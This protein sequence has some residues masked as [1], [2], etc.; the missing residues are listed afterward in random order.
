VGKEASG[1][2]LLIPPHIAF[3]NAVII[4]TIAKK[5]L[6]K[7]PFDKKELYNTK[8]PTSTLISA[9]SFNDI[10]T[11]K[12][13][14]QNGANINHYMP[15]VGSPIDAAITGSSSEIVELLVKSGATPTQNTALIIRMLGRE[16]LLPIVLPQK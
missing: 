13:A 14:L 6:P 5:P 1:K 9:A 2:P 11:I 15:R 3:D 7:L 8:T 4:G 10:E 16:D 12:S